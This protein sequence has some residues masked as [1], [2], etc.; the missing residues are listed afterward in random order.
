[1]N[2]RINPEAVRNG[3]SFREC[4]VTCLQ[5]MDVVREYDRLMGTKLSRRGDL[6][7]QMIDEAT[8]RRKKEMEGF[9]EFCWE[10][11]FLRF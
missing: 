2:P 11:I 6:I 7:G 9:I 1:M 4:M 8:G 5:D 3:I 10:Y